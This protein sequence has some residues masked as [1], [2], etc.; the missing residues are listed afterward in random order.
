MPEQTCLAVGLMSGT[1]MDGVDA[2]LIETDGE[3]VT[4]C[5]PAL[6]HPYD[7]DFRR[8]LRAALGHDPLIRPPENGLVRRLTERHRDAVRALLAEAGTAP[9]DIRVIGFHGH[10][11]LHRPDLGVT[12]QIGDSALLARE[13]GIDVIGDLRLAD[14]AAGGEGAPLAPVYHRALARG[15][16]KPLVVLNLGGVGNVTWIGPDETG[17]RGSLLAFDTGPGNALLDDWMLEKTGES[18]DRG[19][20]LAAQGEV[21]RQVF[22]ALLDNVYFE[23]PPPKSLDRDDFGLA[24]V[25]GLA[26]AAGAATLTA[27]TVATVARAARFFPA[28]AKRWLVT[29][30]G[31]RNATIMQGLRRAL[32]AEVQAVEDAGWSGDALEAQAFAYMAVRSLKGLALTY[33]GTT[34]VGEPLSGGRLYPKGDV[35]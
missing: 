7:A 9:A 18:M 27:F 33:P 22:K 35:G 13:T 12:R 21:D 4:W 5:G 24:P 23:I 29:G 6:T 34:G 17:Y 14:V 1:S 15:L 25:Q 20:A 28:P 32:G 26:A 10:T 19:G 8:D 2:A 16:E 30:G 31:R 11:V 3:A